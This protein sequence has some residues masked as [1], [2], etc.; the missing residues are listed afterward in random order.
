MIE[1]ARIAVSGKLKTNVKTVKHNIHD[2]NEQHQLGLTDLHERANAAT[3][4]LANCIITVRKLETDETEITLAVAHRQSDYRWVLGLQPEDAARESWNRIMRLMPREMWITPWYLLE[5]P[6][7]QFRQDIVYLAEASQMSVLTRLVHIAE[8]AQAQYG[9]DESGRAT[10]G[11]IDQ[12]HKQIAQAQ[13]F[14][15]EQETIQDLTPAHLADMFWQMLWANKPPGKTIRRRTTVTLN[16]PPTTPPLKEGELPDLETMK[17]YYRSYNPETAKEILNALPEARKEWEA[18]GGRWG[19][20]IIA[21]QLMIK[22][23]TVSHYLTAFR[24]AGLR[25]WGSIKLP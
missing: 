5:R 2:W 20:E 22:K 23:G 21:K 7:A 8:A 17:R 9:V 24:M 1:P 15:R 6:Q 18:V 14:K 10:P 4:H 11:A 12:I 25:K 3:W 19:S 13:A 16:P